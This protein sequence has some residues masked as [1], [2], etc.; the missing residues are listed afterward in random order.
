[1][2]GI[3]GVE[4]S[5]S[6]AV[7]PQSPIKI[8]YFAAMGDEEGAITG[9]TEGRGVITTGGQQIGVLLEVD[10]IEAI[11]GE[12]IFNDSEQAKVGSFMDEGIFVEGR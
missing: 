1:M 9:S 3:D 7:L 8:R 11:R 10:T 6:G 4:F 5:K 2:Q 12:S